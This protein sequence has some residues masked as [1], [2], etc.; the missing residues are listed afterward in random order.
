MIAVAVTVCLFA[1]GMA[2]FLNYFKYRST[3][4]RIVK[5]RLIVIGKSIENSI[6]SSLAL[7]L[8]FS[9]LGMLP[10]LM[11]RERAADGLILGIEVFDTSGKFLYST[12]RMRVGRN[13]P[14]PWI[15][16]VRRASDAD[17]HVENAND[18]A[19]GISI[20][21]NFGV[22]VGYLALRYST[23][24]ID[25]AARAIGRELAAASIVIFAF[26]AAL[27]AVALLVVMRRLDRHMREVEATLKRGAG[28]SANDALAR[29]LLGPA[30]VRFFDT[31]R[32]AETQI[33]AVRGKLLRGA[34]R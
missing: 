32:A 9:D 28:P 17:W 30:L 10:E 27:A 34:E 4:E 16:S 29:G 26:A 6:Q 22:T 15:A 11:E 14:E 5:G 7:G 18:S 1:V 31:V 2:G 3:A 13:V 8:S 25:G 21:N 12:D 20:R 19:V 33:A 23:E 24:R